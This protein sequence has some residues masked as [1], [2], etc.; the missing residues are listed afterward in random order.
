MTTPRSGFD[1]LP[2]GDASQPA[3]TGP[4]AK[5]EQQIGMLNLLVPQFG[6]LAASSILLVK[7]LIPLFR[8]H[9]ID[10]G[11]FE[12]EV[13]A[14]DAKLGTLQSSIDAFNAAHPVQPAEPQTPAP[15]GPTL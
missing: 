15:S 10:V 3:G 6:T 9:G 13:A 11:P 1:P 12:Q 5:I 8:K 4:L 14:L 2:T 7:M